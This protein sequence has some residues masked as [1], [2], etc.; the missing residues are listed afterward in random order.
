[1]M[2]RIKNLVSK[3]VKANSGQYD[4][5]SK[6]LHWCMAIIIIYALIAGYAMHLVMDKPKLFHILS[7]LNMSWA[8]IGAFLLVLRWIWRFFRVEPELPSSI[9]KLQRH[10][11]KLAHSVIYLLMLIVF[12]SGFLMLK[13]NYS[14]FWLFEIPNPVKNSEVNAF[15]FSVHRVSCVLLLLMVVIHIIAVVKHR[16]INRNGVLNSMLITRHLSD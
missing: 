2:L 15:F 3:L 4:V 10:I 7:V 6:L 1:M 13:E 11:A 9:P 16:Y 12:V 5:L 14:F 8:T